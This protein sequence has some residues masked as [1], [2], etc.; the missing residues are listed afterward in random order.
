VRI[1]E[2]TPVWDGDAIDR[3]CDYDRKFFEANPARDRYVRPAVPG[4]GFGPFVEVFRLAPGVRLR[5]SAAGSRADVHLLQRLER[6]PNDGTY[7]TWAKVGLLVHLLTDGSEMGFWMFYMWS[8]QHP[9]HNH[10]DTVSFWKKEEGGQSGAA[11]NLLHAM[12][13]W[14]KPL[15]KFDPA[16][17]PLAALT[18]TTAH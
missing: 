2:K 13:P 18:S 11:F 9:R 16:R 12:V 7:Q 14:P 4:E 17:T 5:Q 8:R 1:N 6:I 15:P 3:A 10:D